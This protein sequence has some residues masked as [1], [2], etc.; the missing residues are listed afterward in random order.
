MVLNYSYL[1]NSLSQLAV[2][3]LSLH[4]FFTWKK[5]KICN[6]GRVIGINSFFY[7]ILA[8][9]SF[10][11]AFNIITPQ[12][13]I[14]FLIGGFS[15]S[16]TATLFL[17]IVYDITKYKNLFYLSFIF[18]FVILATSFGF[19]NITVLISGL[20]F[21][22]FM[23]ISIYLFINSNYY[24]KR[25]GLLGIIYSSI[26]FFFVILIYFGVN[27]KI[28]PWFVSHAI[29]F[30]VFYF[31]F[32]DVKHCGIA[33]KEGKGEKKERKLIKYISLGIRYF[34]FVISICLFIFLSTVAVHEVGH[35]F[36]AKIYKCEYSK[37]VVYDILGP[38]HTEMRCE[39]NYNDFILTISGLITT[40]LLSFIFIFTKGVFTTLIAYLI[41][42]FGFLICYGDL[43]DLGMPGSIIAAVMFGGLIITIIGVISLSH[44]FMKQQPELCE[45]GKELK[46]EEHS[47]KKGGVKIKKI[48]IGDE[49]K[50]N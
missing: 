2:A 5:K 26:S 16:I 50:N 3:I 47:T 32:L 1:L 12:A 17:F 27:P 18:L 11:W 13:Q 42:G 19:N 44:Y 48:G 15:F 8:F 22:L 40:I 20:S 46:E 10:L 23:I 36:T 14:I 6:I 4:I 49:K 31:L 34:L 33:E 38:P 35:A 28:I 37:A 25:A 9:L 43:L 30:F 39:T 41:L 45:K 29:M 7:G 21:L 24:L